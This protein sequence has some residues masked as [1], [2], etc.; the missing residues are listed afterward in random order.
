M[1]SPP[2]IIGTTNPSHAQRN[3]DHASKGPLPA[4]VVAKIRAAFQHADPTGAW[5]GLT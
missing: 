2:A 3:I 4:D 1:S 5:P